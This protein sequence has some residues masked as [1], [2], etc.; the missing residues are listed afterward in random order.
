MRKPEE[1]LPVL[2]EQMD[3]LRRRLTVL[4]GIEDCVG[5]ADLAALEELLRQ[6]GALETDGAAV[7]GRLDELR[8][9]LAR[10][11]GVPAAQFTL[12]RLAGSLDGP[13]AIALSDRRERL[14]LLA[15]SVQAQSE[16]TAAL[17]R[18][19]LEFNRQMV[20]A[21][22]GAAGEGPLYAADGEVRS[23]PGRNAVRHCV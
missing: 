15:R 18:H 20:E 1:L 13:L 2:D 3:L 12:G 8:R 6:E 19:A 10:C 14:L 21:L 22:S 16:R 23:Q 7:D 9:A 4:Q 5:R 11:A 17:V